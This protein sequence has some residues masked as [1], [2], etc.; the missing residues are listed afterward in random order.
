LLP[1]IG[2]IL[3]LNRRLDEAIDVGPDTGAKG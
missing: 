2:R 3:T 1:F